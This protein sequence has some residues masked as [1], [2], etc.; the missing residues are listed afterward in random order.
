MTV[1]H[2][3]SRMQSHWILIRGSERVEHDLSFCLYAATEM[4][5]MLSECGF[6]RVDIYG[7][8]DGNAYDHAARRLVA[9]GKKDK[10]EKIKER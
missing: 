6:S 7:D 4:S 10:R 5:A 3:W 2:N 1:T 8:L 9:V